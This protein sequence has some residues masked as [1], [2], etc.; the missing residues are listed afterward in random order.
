MFPAP[1]D[2]KSSKWVNRVHHYTNRKYDHIIKAIHFMCDPMWALTQLHFFSPQTFWFSH[3]P[4][5]TTQE[6]KTCVV[7]TWVAQT[8][9]YLHGNRLLLVE[10]PAQHQLWK[11]ERVCS[12]F[13][14]E[15]WSQEACWKRGC[16][17]EQV[18]VST[19]NFLYFVL[20][21]SLYFHTNSPSTLLFCFHFFFSQPF[22]SNFNLSS[23]I[24]SLFFHPSC[25]CSNIIYLIFVFSAPSL[26]KTSFND[27]LLCHCFSSLPG[28]TYNHQH[29]AADPAAPASAVPGAADEAAATSLSFLLLFLLGWSASSRWP[30]W[31]PCLRKINPGSLHRPTPSYRPRWHTAHQRDAVFAQRL[32]HL[33]SLW[34]QDGINIK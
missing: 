17:F 19:V 11:G 21:I 6:K 34:V 28:C 31:R 33:P 18:L 1:L 5:T 22:P 15:C 8:R 14:H 10:Q 4:L 3:D 26:P 20:S 23:S 25:F 12:P 32:Q 29:A 2:N 16:F 13:L 9:R 24:F 7:T 27:T 30:R